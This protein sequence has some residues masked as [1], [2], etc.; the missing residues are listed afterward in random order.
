[1]LPG[2]WSIARAR[3]T[4]QLGEGG[5]SVGCPFGCTHCWLRRMRRECWGCSALVSTVGHAALAR[6]ST[7]GASA[8]V[9]RRVQRGVLERHHGALPT[10]ARSSGC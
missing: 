9:E 4:I 2:L 8:A 3:T 7:V 5:S 6:A 1:M 10:E